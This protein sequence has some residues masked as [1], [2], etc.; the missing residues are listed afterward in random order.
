[1]SPSS[2]KKT[3][4]P[5]GVT[6]SEIQVPSSV[7]NSSLSLGSSG[8]SFLSAFFFSAAGSFFA[9]G[10]SAGLSCAPSGA[11]RAAASRIVR[12]RAIGVERYRTFLFPL[13]RRG[14]QWGY[15]RRLSNYELRSP[16]YEPFVGRASLRSALF[17][18]GSSAFAEATADKEDP[19]LRV[20]RDEDA[21][22]RSAEG[23]PQ[24]VRTS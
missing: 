8:S 1:M 13:R 16:N 7:S 17:S 18:A 14:E 23:V 22:A 5:S 10:L 20:H 4:F 9:S 21:E 15:S 2:S 19:A 24:M 11:A 6:S 12:S 3:S